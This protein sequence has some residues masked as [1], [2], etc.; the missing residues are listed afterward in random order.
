MRTVIVTGG[1]TGIGLATSTILLKDGYKV[2]AAGLDRE[3]ELPPGLDFVELDVSCSSAVND[4][5]ESTS[6]LHGIVTCAG[7]Q[8]H[9]RE[10]TAEDFAAVIDVNLLSVFN[11]CTMALPK[12]EQ[13][14]G[15]IVNI[16]SMWSIL[17]RPVHP[18]MARAREVL[19][20]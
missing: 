2:I 20:L 5:V 16:A 11:I 13:T 6:S 18:H 4:L 1:G 17:E 7:I 10:W 8:R 19:S 9:D 3:S 15:S 14:G 12:L